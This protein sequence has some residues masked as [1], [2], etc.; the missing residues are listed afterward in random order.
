MIALY[1]D[2]AESCAVVYAVAS[3]AQIRASVPF[4]RQFRR[5]T[6]GSNPPSVHP[7]HGF[8]EAGDAAVG[9]GPSE[10]MRA[11]GSAY[12]NCSTAEPAWGRPRCL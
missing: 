2:P 6:W 4:A 12:L 3:R 9:D 1:C 8:T 10:A 7:Y 11:T 5:N